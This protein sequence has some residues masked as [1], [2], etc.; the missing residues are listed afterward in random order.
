ML[1]SPKR[2]SGVSTLA[3][4]LPRTRTLLTTRRR[5]RNRESVR[6]RA[7][8]RVH[9][10]YFRDY[11]PALG[12]YVESDRL[13][14][15]AGVNTYAYVVN[16]PTMLFDSNGEKAHC[17]NGMVF[18]VTP[19]GGHCRPPHPPTPLEEC[20]RKC[21]VATLIFC[22]PIA[23]GSGQALGAMG[24]AAICV[25][26]PEIC[27][28]AVRGMSIAGGVA[29]SGMCRIISQDACVQKCSR[30]EPCEK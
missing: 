10:N 7:S 6:R 28:A 4:S 24:G 30:N 12:R 17:I 23:F 2:T 3:A 9:Y 20:L 16:R 19:T 5:W 14:L 21:G 25:F 22:R 29:A 11:D 1:R 8:G 26:Q 27:P 15:D 18:E 13:G